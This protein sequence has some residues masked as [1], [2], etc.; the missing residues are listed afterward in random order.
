MFEGLSNDE[1]KELKRALNTMIANRVSFGDAGQDIENVEYLKIDYRLLKH[2][3][4][5]LERREKQKG[6]DFND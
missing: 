4:Q 2:V 1:L 6:F 3:L 5:Q